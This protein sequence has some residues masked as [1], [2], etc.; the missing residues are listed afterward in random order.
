MA[1]R[2]RPAANVAPRLSVIV[3]VYNEIESI[4]LLHEE[5]MGVLDTID[6]SFE[7]Q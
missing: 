4:S 5:L 3:L 1:T 2:I 6:S 7:Q